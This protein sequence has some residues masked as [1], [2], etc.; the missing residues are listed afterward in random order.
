[1]IQF[2]C[3]SINSH[4]KSQ[5]FNLIPGAKPTKRDNLIRYKQWDSTKAFDIFCDH[6]RRVFIICSGAIS[7]IVFKVDFSLSFTDGSAVNEARKAVALKAMSH[8]HYSLIR[9][10]STWLLQWFARYFH[11]NKILTTNANYAQDKK[12]ENVECRT[13]CK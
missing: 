11:F 3:S 10:T 12:E 1:M 8:Q 9:C 4:F 6:Q 13:Q 2:K 7:A 5:L